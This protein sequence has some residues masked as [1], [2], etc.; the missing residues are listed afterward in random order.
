[1]NHE[2]FHEKIKNADPRQTG[3]L[4]IDQIALPIGGVM[5]KTAQAPVRA[6]RFQTWESL[7][8]LNGR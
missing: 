8:G 1:M 5:G 7:W 6:D 2:L 4:G 3:P